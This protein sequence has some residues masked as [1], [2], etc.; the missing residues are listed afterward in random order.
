MAGYIIPLLAKTTI[1]F[2]TLAVGVVEQMALIERVD[3]L[4]WRQVV[5]I[6]RLHQVLIAPLAGS[7]SIIAVGQS[8]TTEEPDTLFQEDI[9]HGGGG[10]LPPI[11]EN[12][13][14]GALLSLPLRVAMPPMAGLLAY[15][16]RINPGALSIVAS[17]EFSVK[18]A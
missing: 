1:D 16:S 3:L 7:I 8:W 5:L 9:S 13:P 6:V 17:A 2:G 4:H 11:N 14:S 15:G 10:W 12:T 18:D